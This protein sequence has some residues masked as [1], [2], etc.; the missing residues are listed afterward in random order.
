MRGFPSDLKSINDS[1][2][3]L[4]RVN[5]NSP[6]KVPT[7]LVQSYISPDWAPL[8][9]RKDYLFKDPLLKQ[10]NF[11]EF[12]PGALYK[13]RLYANPTKKTQGKR[14]GMYKTEE[15]V[16]WL[17]RKGSLGG[18]KLV[19]VDIMG[20]ETINARVKKKSKII[21][22]QAVQFEGILQVIDSNSF[23]ESL[24]NGVGSGKA[25]GFGLLTIFKI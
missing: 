14:V 7:V 11:P 23:R 9:A 16:A 24:E 8:L 3:I 10:F 2:R 17:S 22:L 18:F 19:K 12:V 6:S 1:N 4:F 15:H 5:M 20:S 21:T 25:F 13:F